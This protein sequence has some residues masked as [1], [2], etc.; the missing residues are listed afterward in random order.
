ML[1]MCRH[2]IHLAVHL[3]SSNP[4]RHR[5]RSA[6][7]ARPSCAGAAGAARAPTSKRPRARS[8]RNSLDRL[9]P[10]KFQKAP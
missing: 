10:W 5:S 1:Y 9:G 3:F 8:R 7:A 4:P 2:I 6:S